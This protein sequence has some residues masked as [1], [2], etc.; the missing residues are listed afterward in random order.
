MR[1]SEYIPFGEV[2]D[3]YLNS[4]GVVAMIIRGNDGLA[5]K[6]IATSSKFIIHSA[7][8]VLSRFGDADTYF[9]SQRSC[10]HGEFLHL[11]QRDGLHFS[12][13]NTDGS[14]S[15][16]FILYSPDGVVLFK[17]T[18]PKRVNMYVQIC[19]VLKLPRRTE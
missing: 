13:T 6:G 19:N 14:R 18:Y 15:Y 1:L 4:N 8:E 12:C 16:L 10:V 3:F 9:E 5:Y 2:L 17:S 11:L 7:E